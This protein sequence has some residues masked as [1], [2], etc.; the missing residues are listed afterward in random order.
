ML[1]SGSATRGIYRSQDLVAR[2]AVQGPY[3]LS[4][5]NGETFVLVVPGSER[6]FLDGQRLTRGITADY[7]DCYCDREKRCA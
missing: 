1:A 5:R 6:V 7:G 4:G 2:E 3:R